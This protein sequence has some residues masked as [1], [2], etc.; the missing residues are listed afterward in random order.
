MCAD[1][2]TPVVLRTRYTWRASVRVGVR[3][4]VHAYRISERD[5]RESARERTPKRV[6]ETDMQSARDE[7]EKKK[8]RKN[9]GFFVVRRTASNV[10]APKN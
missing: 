7:R 6:G 9:R 4:G 10:Q 5:G 8:E 3:R 1:T 2:D